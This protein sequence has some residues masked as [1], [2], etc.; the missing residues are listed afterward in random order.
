[1]KITLLIAPVLSEG[2]ENP[3]ALPVELSPPYRVEVPLFAA[4]TK[5]QLKAKNAVWPCVYAPKQPTDAEKYVWTPPE[6]QWVIDSMTLVVQEAMQARANNEVRIA[7]HSI[8]GV[9]FSAPYHY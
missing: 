6:I 1:M 4:R 8:I 7:L 5:A 3:S 2:E 9:S